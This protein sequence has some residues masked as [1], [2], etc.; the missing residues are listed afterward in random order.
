M[1]WDKSNMFGFGL[2]LYYLSEYGIQQTNSL[3]LV[4]LMDF[5]SLLGIVSSCW[6]I[7]Y[8]PIRASAK[9]RTYHCITFNGASYRR[10]KAS[11]NP[12]IILV[13]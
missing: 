9:F 10:I 1:N 12:C 8:T 7:L 6:Y 5:Y 2:F 13:N 4:I 11:K 3:T